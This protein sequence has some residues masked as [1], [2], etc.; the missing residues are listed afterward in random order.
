[1]PEYEF[2]VLGTPAPQ[3][4][5]TRMPN[6]YMA[7]GRSP[8]ARHRHQ[9]WRSAVAEA[10]ARAVG[11]GPPLDGPIEVEVMFR[12]PMPS[13]RPKYEHIIGRRR[14]TSAPDLDKLL[15]ATLDGLVAGGLLVDDARVCDITARKREVVGWTGAHVWI[16]PIV[17]PIDTTE[18]PN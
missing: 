2:Q 13:S 12:F 16:A 4:S 5:K 11:D 14:K 17:I 7:D 9:Q 3:G 18:V 10:A 1:M 6:G 15:R 8:E